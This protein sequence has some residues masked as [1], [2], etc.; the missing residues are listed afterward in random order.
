MAPVEPQ[1][2]L[3]DG[4]IRQQAKV[5]ALLHRSVR[6]VRRC[7][8]LVGRRETYDLPDLLGRHRVERVEPLHNPA[9]RLGLV[10]GPLY[11]AFEAVDVGDHV[12]PQVGEVACLGFTILEVLEPAFE[13]QGDVD[14]DDEHQDLDK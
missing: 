12:S 9:R 6:E 4:V 2:F 7:E 8:E 13:P 10:L 3:L 1:D 11:E 5:A 14:P